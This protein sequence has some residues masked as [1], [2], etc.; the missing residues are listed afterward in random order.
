MKTL[1][2]LIT[3]VGLLIG[4][5]DAQQV[6][7]D[8]ITGTWLVQD[9]SAKIQIQ[10]LNGKYCGKIVWIKQPNDKNGKP[11]LDSKNP[12]KTLQSRPQIGLL[13]LSG[14]VYE[15]NN[16]WSDGTIYDPDG[17]KTYNCKI[18]MKNNNEMDVRGYVGI[19]LFGRTETWA[20]SQNLANN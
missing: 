13:L 17:G 9:G 12:D 18:S 20:R 19:S 5:A 6:K 11:L 3:S 4:S 7:P 16:L 10:N 15:E 14:F 8:A 1:F 2:I